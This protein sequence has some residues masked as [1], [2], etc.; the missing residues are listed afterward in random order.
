MH[1]LESKVEVL[2]HFKKYVETYIINKIPTVKGIIPVEKWNKNVPKY[3]KLKIFGSEAYTLINKE[4]R[5]GK[6]SEK[7]KK[8]FM[9]GY[10]NNGYRLWDPEERKIVRAR[11]IIFNE[12]KKLQAVVHIDQG[13]QKDIARN[14]CEEISEENEKEKEEESIQ[15]ENLEI[16]KRITKR[17]TYLDDYECEFSA[18]SA[19]GIIDN[20]P[21]TKKEALESENKEKWIAAINEEMESLEKHNTWTIV[22]KPKNKRIIHSRWLF[23]IKDI[24]KARLV[25]KGYETS[26]WMDTYAPV[27]KLSTW[28]TLL[29]IANKVNLYIEQMD[30]KTAF[31]NGTLEEDMENDKYICM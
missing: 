19:E 14:N 28:R 10:C 15:K 27:G 11:D 23:K 26:E 25:A 13:I 7:F 12:E 9:V 24:Y 30:V 31:L 21:K 4:N 29:V 6:F 17:P 20:I 18:F 16:H 2:E 3:E 1:L 22:E 8:L 5:K